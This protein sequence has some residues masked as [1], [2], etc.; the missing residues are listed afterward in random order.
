MVAKIHFGVLDPASDP[1]CTAVALTTWNVVPGLGFLDFN[2]ATFLI[3][4]IVL[5]MYNFEPTPTP[6]PRLT[7]RASFPEH[8]VSLAVRS[9]TMTVLQQQEVGDHS[10][11][12]RLC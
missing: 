3:N 1:L 7:C 2:K 5:A 10:R 4:C 11:M 9:V 12:D 6:A 8:A